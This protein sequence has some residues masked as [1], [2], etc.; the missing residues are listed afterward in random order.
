MKS[1]QVSCSYVTFTPY[2]SHHL[3]QVARALLEAGA[4]VNATMNAGATALML[5]ANNGHLTC[6]QL[7]IN[8]GGD[9]NVECSFGTAASLARQN[10]H[11]ALCNL[12]EM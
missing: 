1:N 2:C 12:L 6:A 3:D 9:K 7:L 10:G 11:T 5:A 8:A 4:A